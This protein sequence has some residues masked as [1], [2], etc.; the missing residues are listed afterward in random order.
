VWLAVDAVGSLLRDLP[1]VAS[2]DGVPTRIAARLMRAVLQQLL[3]M[4]ALV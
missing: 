2:V 1:Q 3:R 4:R